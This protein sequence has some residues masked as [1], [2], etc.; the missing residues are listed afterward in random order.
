MSHYV[1]D[2]GKL[3]VAHA[4]M[5]EEM[6][7]R[8]SGKV[9]D[10]ALYGETTG[11]TD[12][13]GLP[14]RFDWASEYRGQ[15]MVVYGHTPVPE[16]DWLNRTV[17]IDTGCVFGGKLT[18]LRY[19]EKEFVSVPA[20]RTYCEPAR[21]FLP[22]EEQAPALSAQQ[23]HDEVLDAEDVLGKR[24]IPTRLR[25]N[26]TIREENATAALE[27][28]SRFAADP[29]WLIYLPPTMSPCETSQAAGLLEHPAEAF[30][31]FR[32]EGVPQVV[33][34]EKHMGSRAVVVVC[35]DE[36]AARERFGVT[37][38]ESGIVIT[39]TGRRFFNDPDLERR[40]LDRVRAALTAADLWA[41]LDTAWVCLDC[42]LM[43]W[44]AKAQE[45]LRT[46]YA[47]VGA[48][49][50]ASL[51]RAVMA[52]EEAGRSPGG[53]G[54]GEARRGRGPVPPAGAGHRSVRGRLPAVLLVGGD[55]LRPQAGPVPPARHRGARPHGQRP[56]LAHGDSGRGLPC[57]SRTPAGDPVQ[58][59]GRDR[60][61]EPGGR[62]RV[63]E[64]TDGAGR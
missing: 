17:N 57:R 29:R 3:V 12:E 53:R 38:G 51:P 48:A 6:Q 33:C 30:A 5:K 24:I 15:A 49:G 28:M 54:A 23:V 40:F 25:G 45:L 60:P 27:V 22:P 63:V 64:G 52:L 26:V 43:P 47:A 21:P 35:R 56:S 36:K 8:G 13:F 55:A 4:G 44:S 59:R 34:E 58:G 11:E 62:D 18:A 20:A 32:N 31:Y 37:T 39:R 50:S 14:V 2:D 19:P 42:E 61:G 46:Q 9:R 10:F 1:L 16:P 41:K 7:G